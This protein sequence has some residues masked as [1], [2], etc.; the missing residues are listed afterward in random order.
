MSVLNLICIVHGKSEI[1]ALGI[2]LPVF[3]D[4]ESSIYLRLGAKEK[5]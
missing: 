4:P 2:S 3:T 1:Y 5:D